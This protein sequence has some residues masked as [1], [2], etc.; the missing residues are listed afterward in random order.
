MRLLHNPQ[1]AWAPA[2]DRSSEGAPKRAVRFGVHAL[3]M[4]AVMCLGG[5]LLMVLFFVGASLLGYPDLLQTA[6]ALSALVVATCLAASMVAWMRLRGMEWRPTLEM[7]GSS[8]AVGVL[9]IAGYW[10]GIVP[11]TLLIQLCGV[12]CVAMIAIMFF[13]FDL[14]ASH[15]GHHAPAG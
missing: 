12:A 13:R 3:E 6:P 15:A 5:G 8:I 1:A 2:R 7:A 9:M 4:C 11:G 14:Y 10:L